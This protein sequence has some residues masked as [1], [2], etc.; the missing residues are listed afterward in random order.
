MDSRAHADAAAELTELGD[1]SN[2]DLYIAEEAESHVTKGPMKWNIWSSSWTKSTGYT[3][4]YI[5]AH[6]NAQL[7][8]ESRKQKG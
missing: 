4:T 3:S 6:R 2:S 7:G 8:T 1:V 5:E